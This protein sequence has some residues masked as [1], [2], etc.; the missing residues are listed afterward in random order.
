MG[1]WTTGSRG[2]RPRY[3]E[4][5]FPV[6]PMDQH[7]DLRSEMAL[8][9]MQLGIPIEVQH[10]EVGTAGQAEMDMRYAS[11]WPWRTTS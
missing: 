7:Q 9:L 3:K 4:G 2:Y 6:P 11:C 1:V 10:H 5:Y 8:T